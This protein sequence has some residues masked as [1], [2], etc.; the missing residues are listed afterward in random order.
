MRI[1]RMLFGAVFLVSVT[2]GWVA[3]QTGTPKTPADGHTIHAVAPH[4]V[5]GKVMGPFHH[6]CKVLSPSR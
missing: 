3:A 5:N 2:V 1:T 6:Y 4:V